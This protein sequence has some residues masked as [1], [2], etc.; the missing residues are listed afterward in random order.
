MKTL[1]LSILLS[2]SLI[3]AGTSGCGSIMNLTEDRPRVYGGTEMDL[4]VIGEVL[5]PGGGTT[6]GL[7]FIFFIPCVIDL[8]LSFAVDTATI[9]IVVIMR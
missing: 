1:R 6:F 5:N 7:E 3:L 2:A 8:P 4:H 9:P